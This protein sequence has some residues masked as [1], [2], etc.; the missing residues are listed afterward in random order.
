MAKRAAD[1]IKLP[2]DQ[3]V[4]GAELVKRLGQPGRSVTVPLQVSSYSRS[5]PTPSRASR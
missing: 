5:Q 2:D 3:G 1:A 4:A